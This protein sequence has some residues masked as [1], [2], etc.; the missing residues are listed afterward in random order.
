MC[1]QQQMQAAALKQNSYTKGMNVAANN[2]CLEQIAA[3]LKE[4]GVGGVKG[5]PIL[6][7]YLIISCLQLYHQD[8]Q[9]FGSWCFFSLG[10]C[11]DLCL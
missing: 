7:Q 2:G 3:M 1:A 8:P 10:K 4:T 9:I 5:R 11:V 6:E